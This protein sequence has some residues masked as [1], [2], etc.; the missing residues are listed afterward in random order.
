MATISPTD[1]ARGKTISLPP[2]VT[3]RPMEVLLA[4]GILSSLLYIAMNVVA[5][6]RFEGYSTVSQTISELSAIGAPTRSLWVGMAILYGVL[7]IAFGVGVWLAA[8]GRR[9][10][11]IA[12]GLLVAN[13]LIGLAW[14]P[15]HQRGAATSLTDTLHIAWTAMTLPMVMAAILFAA[16][17]FGKRFRVY[18]IATI[19][20]MLFFGFLTGLDGPK[21]PKDLPTPFMGVWERISIASFMLW[22]VVLAVTLLRARRAEGRAAA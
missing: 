3:T 12:G 15:M 10:L 5:A 19:V 9:A 14:P 1:R 18:S 21:I 16:S 4:C 8:H 11:R 13:A 20:T 6:L 2:P 17:V 22:Y 7:L